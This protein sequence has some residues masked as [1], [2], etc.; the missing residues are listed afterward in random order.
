MKALIARSRFDPKNIDILIDTDRQY[1][2]PT[3]R[4]VKVIATVT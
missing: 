2:S 4:N 1:T 3:G